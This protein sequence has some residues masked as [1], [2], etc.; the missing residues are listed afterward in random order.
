ML[1]SVVTGIGVV[2]PIGQN[3][4]AYWDSLMS[5]TNGLD[6]LDESGMQYFPPRLAGRVRNSNSKDGIPNRLR[7]QTDVSTKHALIA[8]SDCLVD[9]RI[10]EGS[11]SEFEMAVVSSTAIGGLSFTHDELRRLWSDGPE[12]VSVY[13]SFAWFYAVN[14]GQISIRHGMRGP[15]RAIVAGQAGGL[16]AIGEARRAIRGGSSLALCG[17]A[18]SA[19]DS[20]GWA[21]HISTGEASTK[22]FRP[23][24][25]DASGY[26]P[27]EGAA[28]LTV[29]SEPSAR[30]R[31]AQIYG[32]IAGYAA[33]FDPAPGVD[34]APTLRRAAENALIDAG[35]SHAEVD[36]VYADAAGVATADSIEEK[37]LCDIY[38]VRGVPVATPKALVGRLS[39]AGGP[40]DIA[41]AL[42]SM[43][44]GI[45]PGTPATKNVTDKLD[46]VTQNRQ[47]DIKN[48]L[49]LA[50]GRCGFNS[51]VV[52]RSSIKSGSE[53]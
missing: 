44:N 10:Q 17:G 16:D 8:A 15:T 22:G 26:A 37:M 35:I 20:L 36:V 19:L 31:G 30:A 34:R 52:L 39:A 42:L 3:Y 25:S 7:P 24:H 13:A 41:T 9:A 14:T 46:L 18:D 45:V 33:T 32:E 38:G 12:S 28:F 49:V 4:S 40:L 43:K 29:E 23:F 6:N 21:A 27:G 1:R 48:A 51:A 53:K 5:G 47:L 2:S 50:R 11:F